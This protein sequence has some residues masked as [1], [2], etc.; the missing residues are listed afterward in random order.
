MEDSLGQLS[1]VQQNIVLIREQRKELNERHRQQLKKLRQEENELREKRSVILKVFWKTE[2]IYLKKI[3][4]AMGMTDVQAYNIIKTET[5][6]K[7]K[8]D[9]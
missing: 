9:K 5:W 8:K 6:F 4:K 7:K 1:A 3:A 2:E